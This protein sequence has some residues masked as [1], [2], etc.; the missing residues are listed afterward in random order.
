M[1]TIKIQGKLLLVVIALFL[2]ATISNGSENADRPGVSGASITKST[3]LQA[4][5]WVPYA[6]TQEQLDKLTSLAVNMGMWTYAVV[7]GGAGNFVCEAAGKKANEIINELKL[8]QLSEPLS[9]VK[10]KE[11]ADANKI[12]ED[13]GSGISK[14][15]DEKCGDYFRIKCYS[16]AAQFYLSGLEKR[17]DPL[18]ALA[19][20]VVSQVGVKNAVS[21][22]ERIGVST[23]IVQDGSGIADKI[24]GLMAQIPKSGEA[25]IDSKDL[26]YKFM[27]WEKSAMEA[28]TT[29]ILS[30]NQNTDASSF[31]AALDL[32]VSTSNMLQH[33]RAEEIL[34]KMNNFELKNRTD[35]AM[36]DST[37]SLVRIQIA[38][39]DKISED[40]QK[41]MKDPEVS[42]NNFLLATYSTLASASIL[43]S[44][45]FSGLL[46]KIEAGKSEQKPNNEI[47][48]LIKVDLQEM[49]A[50][51]VDK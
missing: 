13:I 27:E 16:I 22:A 33:N 24:L 36:V 6:V 34:S 42:D 4:A 8:S 11:W 44:A 15:M 1:N 17:K 31:K 50:K 26:L 21:A 37:L 28:A 29:I 48:A 45:T 10:T 2:S 9:C 12:I 25:S 7:F 3:P 23:G 35:A 38:E 43:T 51:Y 39:L 20:I 30:S 18:V 46:K 19:F 5:A 47:V 32:A 14:A 49:V 40:N 41:R